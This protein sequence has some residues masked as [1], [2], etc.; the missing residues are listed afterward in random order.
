MG[1]S[2]LIGIRRRNGEFFISERWT[3]PTTFWFNDP[4][5][6][7]DDEVELQ[8]YID[9]ENDKPQTVI[10]PSEYGVILVDF[11]RRRVIS[12]QDYTSIGRLFTN[13]TDIEKMEIIQKL[14]KRG[15]VKSVQARL[16]SGQTSSTWGIP[17]KDQVVT[18]DE[19]ATNTYFEL[20]EKMITAEQ[21]W[22][23][24]GSP[25]GLRPAYE[26]I[27]PGVRDFFDITWEIPGLEVSDIQ[28]GRGY[29]H[30]QD[31]LKWV[32]E[33]EW[34]TPVMSMQDVTRMYDR[35]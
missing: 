6:Y 31:V 22:L 2:V 26:S 4:D 32:A 23:D 14:K 12:R 34:P 9:G 33:N 28:G 18:L 24:E 5:F 15:F 29:C 16:P 7:N 17:D 30:W 11:I 35:D 13:F 20:L 1:G 8:E 3:N 19:A 21:T 10:H 25:S 27:E